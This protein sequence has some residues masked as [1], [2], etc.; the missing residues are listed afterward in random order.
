MD[1]LHGR[2]LFEAGR[3]PV[4]ANR[5]R[6]HGPD[7]PSHDHDFFELAVV[8]K[9]RG[10]HESQGGRQELRSG[11]AFLL[12]PG[13]WH[14][15]RR[16]RSLDVYNCCFAPGLL[17][18]ELAWM[19][20][21]PACA[22]LFWTGAMAQDRRGMI[23]L[24]LPPR[25]LR[26]CVAHLDAIA[27]AR[28]RAQTVGSLTLLLG[29][30]S[31]AAV[32]LPSEFIALHPAVARGTRLLES[33]PAA[34][35]TL[36]GLAQQ[37]RLNPAYLVRLFRRQVGLPPL[38]Y[39]NRLRLERAAAMLLSTPDRVSDIA[40]AVGFP[41][42]NY[43]ARRFRAHW[44]VTARVYRQRRDASQETSASTTSRR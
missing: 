24:R 3:S 18:R 8:V 10:I 5:H 22:G 26:R 12:R 28:T 4:S 44:G 23:A 32:S 16:C 35:W 30:V 1:R 37:V 33:D 13:V 38:A 42:A 25:G 6:L 15:Y 34:A 36:R 40:G 20:E 9:G 31:Q 43:F 11:D 27:H 2:W 7:N 19:R 21:D 41:D 29:E 17:G 14:A 39:L